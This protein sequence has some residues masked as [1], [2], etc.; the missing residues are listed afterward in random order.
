MKINWKIAPKIS[1]AWQDKFPEINPI[2][3][4]LLINRGIDSQ[5][6]VDEFL[7][8]DYGEDLHNPF[9]FLEMEKIVKR[10]FK[11][12]AKK[13]KILVWGDYD[14]DGICSATLLY[15]TLKE[16]GA[17]VSVYLPDRELEGCGLNKDEIN[18][19]AEEKIKLI[20]TV[21][22][23]I[24][25]V[26]EVKLAGELG[27]EVII[28][29]HH[30]EPKKLPQAYAII[31]PKLKKGKYP[32]RN[33]AG[34]GVAF[35]LTQALLKIFNKKDTYFEKWLLDLVAIG[36][37]SDLMPLLGENRT[38]VKYGLVV[39]NKTRR[40]GLKE[41][42]K[43]SRF[44]KILDT[45]FIS[46]QLG[47]RLNAASRIDHA[48]TAFELII[49]DSQLEAKKIAEKLN[50]INYERQL[51]ADKIMQ[52]VKPQI[53]EQKKEK[54]L[55]IETSKNWNWPVGIIGL[56][57]GKIADDVQKPT[58]VI[59]A[60][61]RDNFQGS[62]RS[63]GGFDINALIE[64]CSKYLL[65]YG[66]HAEASGFGLKTE[67]LIYF[68]NQ[69]R[70]MAEKELKDRDL[71]T[72]IKIDVKLKLEEINFSLYEELEKLE[73]FGKNNERPLFLCANLQVVGLERLGNSEQ[74]L[75][76]MAI[77]NNFTPKKFI[78]F[79]FGKD[80]GLKLKIGDMVDIIFE[81][82]IN[83]W[84]GNSE[85]QLKIIDLDITNI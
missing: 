77:Q 19:L 80:I 2:I 85:L 37:V 27:M 61:K 9:L 81:I 41:L 44:N 47:P 74:H 13:E 40:K 3:L 67:N 29:D 66:G 14:A 58:I 73:P 24:S 64:K 25:N 6:K 34:A 48:N 16:L 51:M 75:K 36:T 30:E 18:K 26:E 68:K 7:N 63:F 57:A 65:N 55:I 52:E 54:L 46:F 22:C 84:N 76:I 10:I 38:L 21:D 42:I 15:L 1:S 32:F 23:G 11:A 8:P 79:G 17:K 83:E 62:S 28:T 20:I 43:I 50:R 78:G 60:N 69:L 5:K 70:A 49:T 31:N 33:L 82:G 35:K 56:I 72:T 53:E 39:L 12:I 4:Q 71:I 59:T 45:N